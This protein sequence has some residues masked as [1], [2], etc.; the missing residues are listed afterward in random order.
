MCFRPGDVAK[1]I[2]CPNCDNRVPIVAG[3]RPEKCPKCGE[4]L[5][6]EAQQPAGPT[7]AAAPSA[8]PQA[9]AAPGAPKAPGA[10]Q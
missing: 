8:S 10:P 3:F 5:P 1:P 9:P 4:P 7:A 2:I 6:T